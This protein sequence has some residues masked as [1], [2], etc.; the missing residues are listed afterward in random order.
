MWNSEEQHKNTAFDIL[1]Q[2][3]QFLNEKNTKTNKQKTKFP[4]EI[5]EKS[6]KEKNKNTV[7]IRPRLNPCS[8]GCTKSLKK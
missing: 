7:D 4:L 2:T 5:I 8:S 6:S 3:E 1:A